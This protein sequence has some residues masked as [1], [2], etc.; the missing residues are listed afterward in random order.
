MIV[1]F[2]HVYMHI[3]SKHLN[4]LI[5]IIHENM[6]I[7]Y[8]Y[9]IHTRAYMHIQFKHANIC[10]FSSFTWIHAYSIC[11]FN[12]YVWICAYSTHKC[13]NMRIHCI[14]VNVCMHA[15]AIHRHVNVYTFNMYDSR[16]VTRIK[17]KTRTSCHM[18]HDERYACLVTSCRYQSTHDLSQ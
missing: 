13:E 12:S 2:I 18:C 16:I 11:W 8:T 1:Q 17:M 15:Y 10:V 7:Q 3:W 14:H 4:M 9:S 5:Q 6:Q